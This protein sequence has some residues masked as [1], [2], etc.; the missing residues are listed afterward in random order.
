[1]ARQREQGYRPTKSDTGTAWVLQVGGQRKYIIQQTTIATAANKHPTANSRQNACLVTTLV[2]LTSEPAQCRESQTGAAAPRSS[3]SP[4]APAA[5]AAAA[6]ATGFKLSSGHKT[7]V[8]SAAAEAAA[9]PV[10]KGSGSSNH[11]A[12]EAAD[13]AWRAAAEATWGSE[14]AFGRAVIRE[15]GLRMRQRVVEVCGLEFEV[16]G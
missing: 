6:A 7:P 2:P 5:A 12:A 13:A 14:E 3:H 8:E 4:E 15:L 10:E 9:I 1:M 11:L 16:W